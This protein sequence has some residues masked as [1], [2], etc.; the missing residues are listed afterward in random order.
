MF[1]TEAYN[2][3]KQSR[4]RFRA[5]AGAAPVSSAGSTGS[6]P[7]YDAAADE[8]CDFLKSGKAAFL[9]WTAQ[10]AGLDA[11]VTSCGSLA[12]KSTRMLVS[13]AAPPPENHKMVF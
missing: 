13:S 1:L 2:E 10:K 3:I 11:V 7:I 8:D 6:R 5:A 12:S 4:A 9:S